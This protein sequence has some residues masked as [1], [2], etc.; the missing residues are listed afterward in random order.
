MENWNKSENDYYAEVQA[1]LREQIS[2]LEKQHEQ[3][4]K[5]TK[6]LTD[7]SEHKFSV[8]MKRIQN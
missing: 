3:V 6:E 5:T 1:T 2:K 8:Q 4:V 7:R